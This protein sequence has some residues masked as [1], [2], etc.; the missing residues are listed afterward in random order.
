M[1]SYKLNDKKKVVKRLKAFKRHHSDRYM[2]V[3]ESWRK[4]R[5]IDSCVRRRFRGTV[6][7]VNIGYKNNNATR[8]QIKGGLR[9]FLINNLSD[10]EI[11]LMNNQT[12]AGEI[13]STVSAKLRVDILNRA[14]ELGVS[15]TNAHGRVRKTPVE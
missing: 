4:P 12:H 6:R 1:G 3:G 11:L 7:M 10:I 2:R 5:G 14:R 15:I 13:A 8:H 9:K